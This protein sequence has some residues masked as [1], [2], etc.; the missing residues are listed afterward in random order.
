DRCGGSFRHPSLPRIFPAGASREWFYAYRECAY[1]FLRA[2]RRICALTS[3][4]RS[5]V[6]GS[7]TPCAL[8]LGSRVRCRQDAKDCCLS[9]R[10]QNPLPGTRSSSPD[11]GLGTHVRPSANRRRSNPTEQQYVLCP[12][13]KKVSSQGPWHRPIRRPR[14]ARAGRAQKRTPYPSSCRQSLAQLPSPDKRSFSFCSSIRCSANVDSILP[15]MS[16]GARSRNVSLDS[17]FSLDWIA[18]VSPSISFLRR[19]DSAGPSTA[20]A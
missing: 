14:P 4:Y 18:F 3:R 9:R 11:R 13:Q 2:S 12:L 5:C 7:L 16:A 17:C 8:R 19:A 15:R 6:Q 1:S 20:S 10:L